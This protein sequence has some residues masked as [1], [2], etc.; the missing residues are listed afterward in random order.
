MKI[1]N[2][3][4]AV[5]TFILFMILSVNYGYAD[6]NITIHPDKKVL[7]V[8]PNAKACAIIHIEL[9]S[10]G[11][12]YANPKGEGTGKATTAYAKP[13]QHIVPEKTRYLPG[14]LYISPLDSKPVYIYNKHTAL[15]IPFEVKTTH[16]GTYSLSITIEALYCNDVSCTPIQ[17]T[18]TQI[19]NVNTSAPEF[20][21]SLCTMYKVPEAII[22]TV[23]KKDLPGHFNVIDAG[24]TPTSSL[25]HAIMFGILAGFLLNFMPCVLPVIS[26]KILSFISYGNNKPGQVR[27][28]GLLFTAGILTSFLAL[29]SLAAFAGY[30]WG[31]LF[32]H[33]MF[34]I[35]MAAIIFALALSFFG[36][37][38]FN[39]PRLP[40]LQSANIYVDSYFKGIVATLLAT[41]CSGPFLG[42][43][44]AWSLTQHPFI[45]F[46][47]FINIGLGMSLPYLL[48][49]FY[50]S[51]IRFIPKPGDWMITFEQFMGFLMIAT[52]MYLITLLDASTLTKT[53]WFLLLVS[54][55]LWQWGRFG[56][57]T[58]PSIQRIISFVVLVLLV[59]S[60]SMIFSS[61]K[62]SQAEITYKP[63][64]WEAIVHNNTSQVAMVIFTAQ[65]CPN[66]KFVEATALSSSDVIEF[67]HKNNIAVYK[68]DI[69][70]KNPPAET[71]LQQLGSRSIPFVAIFP[72][73][74][75][76][77]QPVIL[78][79]IY[80]AKDLL[81]A[82][83][84][85]IEL[86]KQSEFPQLLTIP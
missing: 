31:E 35:I 13:T 71:I 17:Q 28:M 60:A 6:T 76:F 59:V 57:I 74:D 26:L 84:K 51:L 66:C 15:C 70:T 7:N 18:I 62:T 1:S 22:H 52:T 21:T 48:L 75:N 34:I 8:K 16:E 44:L 19:I 25:F 33:K 81:K 53:I 58:K 63:Y 23:N 12:I 46:M 29:A 82:L 24:S 20:D 54:I 86:S 41:P 69:T 39:I 4:L 61:K 27:I 47:V 80:T 56:N 64:D 83:Q 43:T 36:V 50:P 38:T 45:I 40:Q 10:K 55:G 11:Y 49:S 2:I 65:W 32:Q 77:S 14:T 73:G 30:N 67:I 79:D 42:A 72:S 68:A 37:Y 5:Y 3:Y 85:A 78:R 9:P